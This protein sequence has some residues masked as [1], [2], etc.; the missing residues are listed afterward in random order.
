MTEISP[1]KRAGC[2]VTACKDEN[3][4][5]QKG[6]LRLGTWVIIREHGSW[7]WRHW[8]CVSGEQVMNMQNKIGKDKNGEYNWD[9]IDGWE[10]LE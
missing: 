6:E 1:N 3:I 9:T 2:K 8:G 4:K 7:Q 10:D 5:I